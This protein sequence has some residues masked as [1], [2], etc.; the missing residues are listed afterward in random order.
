MTAVSIYWITIFKWI[1]LNL[2]VV[3]IRLIFKPKRTFWL[4][5]YYYGSLMFHWHSICYLLL[6]SLQ[7]FG[8]INLAVS[9]LLGIMN[10]ISWMLPSLISGVFYYG[11][12]L[13]SLYILMH[14]HNMFVSGDLSKA[15]S[16][17]NKIP[18]NLIDTLQAN[19]GLSSSS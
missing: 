18:V 9:I 5:L 19:F 10:I 16:K 14:M 7:Y 2:N 3:Y 15:S 1:Y 4:T 8:W 11:L 12:S 6:F 13:L 17:L